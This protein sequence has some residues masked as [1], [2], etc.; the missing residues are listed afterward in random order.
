MYLRAR[1]FA[2]LDLDPKNLDK[3]ADSTRQKVLEE[4]ASRAG[5]GEQAGAPI[6][7]VTIARNRACCQEKYIVGELFVRTNRQVVGEARVTPAALRA[8][9]G[10]E[11]E[12]DGLREGFQVMEAEQIQAALTHDQHFAQA[13]FLSPSLHSR[14]RTSTFQ[15]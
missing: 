4:R 15:D 12:S 11:L 6:S 5:F 7:G 13:G 2:S 14:R 9:G 10:R 8:G 1:R 3:E